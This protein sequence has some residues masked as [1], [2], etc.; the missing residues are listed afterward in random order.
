M[1]KGDP[2]FSMSNYG[3][4]M[5]GTITVYHEEQSIVIID[6][7]AIET[8]VLVEKT[9]DGYSVYGASH[10]CVAL[11]KNVTLVLS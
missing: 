1:K 8:A 6:C 3:C 4:G 10:G 11:N 5:M 7:S 2:I 9:E